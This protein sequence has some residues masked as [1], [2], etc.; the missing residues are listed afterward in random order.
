MGNVEDILKTLNE[1]FQN[2]PCRDLEESE[3]SLELDSSEFYAY[4]GILRSL[5][6][7]ELLNAKEI[8]D[9]EKY[10]E[11]LSYVLKRTLEDKV[12][13][14]KKN[15]PVSVLLRRFTNKKSK[16]VVESRKELMER[17][18]HLSFA[19]QRK[20]VIAF[21]SST[22]RSDV[23]WAAEE[24]RKRWDKSY[25]VPIKEAFEKR[26]SDS[27]ALTIIQHMPL[28]YLREMES[29]LVLHNRSEYC[30]RFP[31]EADDLMKQYDF[32][33]FEMLYVKARIGQNLQ[34]SDQHIERRFFRFIYIFAQMSLLDVCRGYENVN[35]IPCLGRTLQALGELGYQ[36]ILLQFLSMR[37][38]AKE[39]H[40]DNQ[41]NSE[42]YYAQKWIK[43]NYFQ[44]AA[45]V[46][47][48]NHYYVK[49]AVERFESPKHIMVAN[50]NDLDDYDDLPPDVIKTIKD[51][52]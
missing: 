11:I 17:F 18:E 35:D 10:A 25:L 16:R 3:S 21:L 30:M 6:K 43:E 36:D 28:E 41:A 24:A 26:D 39:R 47:P 22:N 20:I 7:E 37:K 8:I 29:R 34:F 32:N 2:K 46:E 15:E 44:E 13:T 5:P 23:D 50:V 40:I 14:Y 52:I 31:D 42:L 1:Y 45:V 48:F 19:D 9:R 38:Y 51:L 33:I 49:E 12:K 4:W 27:V